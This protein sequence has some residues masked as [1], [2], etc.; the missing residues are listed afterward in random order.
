MP[1]SSPSRRS[2]TGLATAG[3]LVLSLTACGDGDEETLTVYSG[4]SEDLVQPLIDNFAEESGIEVEVRYGGTAE[5]A[6]QL[7]EEGDESPAEV[8]L[9]QDAG[10]L[11]AVAAEGLLVP[12]PEETLGQ[13]PQAYRSADGRWV[14]VT[15]RARVLVHHE[16]TV[17]ADELPDSVLDLTGPEWNGRVGVAPTNASFQA[18]VTALRIQHG[19]DVAR[20]WLED[21]AANDPQI[22]ERNGE[23]V[24]DV[25]AGSIDVGL[26]NHYYVYEL[27]QE[28]GVDAEELDVALHFFPGGDTGGLVNISGVGLVGES[29]EQAMELVDHL[30]SVQGQEYFRDETHEYPLI[31]GVDADPGLPS[32]EELEVPDIDL[33]DLEDLQTT[34]TMITEAGLL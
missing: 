13:V 12:L 14:G 3:A 31:E 16:P 21:L 29:D 30:L 15:G 20:Q 1:M 9:A 23:I 25:D 6:A 17:P 18:F 2:L 11:G 5:L 8:F 7:L 32:L 19:D 34:V 4:R 26:V 27:A 10:A 28:R 33:N 22:R 24:A